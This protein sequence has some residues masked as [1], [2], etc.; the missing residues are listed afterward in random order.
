MNTEQKP[1]FVKIPQRGK[2]RLEGEDTFTFLQD[3]ITNDIEIL[4]KNGAMYACLLNA[5]GKFQ[6]DFLMY[7]DGD[8]VIMDCEGGAR[9]TDLFGRLMMYRL[10]AKINMTKENDVDTYVIMGD[11]SDI[12]THQGFYDPRS[13]TL[14][15]RTYTMPQNMDEQPFDIWDQTRIRLA[16]PDGSRDMVLERSNLIESNLGADNGI[17]FTKGCYIGQELTARM[18]NRGLSKRHLYAVE[19]L[20][21]RYEDDSVIIIGTKTIGEIRSQC[22][23]LALASIKD[24]EIGNLAEAGLQILE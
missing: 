6:H 5:Q 24:S 19:L 23:H 10:R 4:Q 12:P 15:F 16:I 22:G 9:T 17:S 2:L 1:F 7:L 11:I 18:H 20:D 8:A 14:G 3:I 13:K 21:N